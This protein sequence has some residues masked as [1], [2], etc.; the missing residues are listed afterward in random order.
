MD[1]KQLSSMMFVI[2]LIIGSMFSFMLINSQLFQDKWVYEQ[3][4]TSELVGEYTS[5]ALDENGDPHISYRDKQMG[6]LKHAWLDGD[7]WNFET[8]DDSGMVEEHT[9][10]IIDDENIPHIWYNRFN[11]TY[12]AY[13]VNDAWTIAKY[14]DF[15]MPEEHIISED[16]DMHYFSSEWN[17]GPEPILKYVTI[18][19]DSTY[20]ETIEN[21]YS[22]YNMRYFTYAPDGEYI[23]LAYQMTDIYAFETDPLNYSKLIYGEFDGSEWNFEMINRSDYWNRTGLYSD[24]ILDSDGEPHIFY[25]HEGLKHAYIE[26][27]DWK[28]ESIY[29]SYLDQAEYVE[30]GY[31]ISAVL[32]SND[33]PHVVFYD[34]NDRILRMAEKVDGEW[35]VHVID[36]NSQV[37]RFN[38]IAIDSE[39]N[40]H[41]SYLDDDNGSLKYA[42]G[43]Y[44]GDF[45]LLFMAISALIVAVFIWILISISRRKDEKNKLPE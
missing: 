7:A 39:D 18:S 22:S 13:K 36:E 11:G 43:T 34:G 12:H 44:D 37:G 2:V 41:I 1:K 31:G 28:I 27:N 10:M 40:I 4:D 30:G 15:K 29:E 23:H 38:S 16:G 25:Y 21:S 17:Y 32:D 5:I 35:I 8:V 24:M 3:V 26:N 42:K 45:T 14:G 33:E 19:D 20:S 9:K 6:N